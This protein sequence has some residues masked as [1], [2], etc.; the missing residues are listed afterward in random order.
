[1]QLPPISILIKR[2]VYFLVICIAVGFLGKLIQNRNPNVQKAQEFLYQSADVASISGKIEKANLW[3]ITSFQGGTHTS[4]ETFKGYDEYQFGIQ[5][6]S[7]N[8]VVIIKAEDSKEG[9]RA[10]LA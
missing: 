3:E 9:E 6:S 2:A 8:F 7:G 10:C 1:M 5:G 4:G